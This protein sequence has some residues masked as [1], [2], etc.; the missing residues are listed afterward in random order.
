M[1]RPSQWH[2]QLLME[3]NFLHILMHIAYQKVKYGNFFV[4]GPIYKYHTIIWGSSKSPT[5]WSPWQLSRVKKTDVFVRF[6]VKI[7]GL[8]IVLSL[9]ING[10]NFFISW[11]IFKC[12]TIIWGRTKNATQLSPSKLFRFKKWTFLSV[13]GLRSMFKL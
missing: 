8:T 13:F 6:R 3:D 10:P 5:R 7:N 9:G 1:R 11:L 4:L 12:L 2:H